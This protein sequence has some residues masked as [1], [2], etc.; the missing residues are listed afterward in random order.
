MRR[1]TNQ[2]TNVASKILTQVVAGM[3]ERARILELRSTSVVLEA[4][5]E[6][7]GHM[8]RISVEA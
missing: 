1:T 7:A 8:G 5:G 6:D 3:P 2:L 4:H